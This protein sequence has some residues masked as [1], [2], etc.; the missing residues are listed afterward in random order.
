MPG[1]GLN[2]HWLMRSHC[3]D[4]FKVFIIIFFVKV[5]IY[6]E[7]CL[8]FMRIRDSG[9]FLFHKLQS[10][11]TSFYKDMILLDKD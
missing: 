3:S 7:I 10:R 11:Q 1:S 5:L 8:W 6:S 2:L 4:L 9:R